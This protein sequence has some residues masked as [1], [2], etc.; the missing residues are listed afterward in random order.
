MLLVRVTALSLLVPLPVKA[1]KWRMR[2]RK[3]LR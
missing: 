1:R 3:R 2:R